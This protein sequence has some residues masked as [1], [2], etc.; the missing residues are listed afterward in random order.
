MSNASMP[1]M[2]VYLDVNRT[3]AMM[4]DE[5]AVPSILQMAQQTLT[6]EIRQLHLLVDSGD[7]IAAG[8]VL[9]TIKGSLPIFCGDVLVE[10]VAQLEKS[11]K[12]GP[13]PELI[14]AFT[15]ISVELKK[16]TDEIVNYLSK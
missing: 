8:R 12:Q 7:T 9:H 16:L 3:I 5:A 2:Y 6:D 10:Q 1:A 13:A 15:A 4:G 11:S 14:P